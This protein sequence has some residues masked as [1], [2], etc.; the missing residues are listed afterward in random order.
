MKNKIFY[1]DVEATGL[2][3]S[4]HDIIQLGAIIEIEGEVIETLNYNIQPTNWTTID[5]KALQVVGVSNEALKTYM[6]PSAVVHKLITTFD[7]YIDKYDS[8]DKFIPVGHNVEF[9][10]NFLYKLFTSQNYKY[11]GSYINRS[12]ALCTL[13]IS[14]YESYISNSYP[15]DFKLETLSKFYKLKVD[16]DFHDAFTDILVTRALL[17]HYL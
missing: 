15:P 17:Q 4:K 10:L 16:G 5:D 13:C 3:P 14:R 8:S 7:R 12:R 11:L 6:E 2:Y 9:D 1:F